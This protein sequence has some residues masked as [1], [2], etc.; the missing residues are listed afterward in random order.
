MVTVVLAANV[1]E[2]KSQFYKTAQKWYFLMD[3]KICLLNFAKTLRNWWLR[4]NCCINFCEIL[5]ILNK[6]CLT[7]FE[8]LVP[9]TKFLR[10]W[11]LKIKT[12]LLIFAHFY[13]VYCKYAW[14]ANK[15]YLKN[16]NWFIFGV[17]NEY[18]FILNYFRY[19]K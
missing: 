12:F 10:N 11:L 14:L 18:L 4:L 5:Y 15:N 13:Y 8:G 6:L 2:C 16:K 17:K 9:Q 1:N 7:G 3:C 19:E